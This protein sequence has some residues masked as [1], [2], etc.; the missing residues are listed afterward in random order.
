MPEERLIDPGWLIKARQ[1]RKTLVAQLA[2][3]FVL[4]TVLA[5]WIL[6]TFRDRIEDIRKAVPVA[7]GGKA[8]AEAEKLPALASL[9]ISCVGVFKVFWVGIAVGCGAGGLLALTGKIDTL[10]PLLNWIVLAVGL[11]AVALSFYVLY[12]PTLTLLQRVS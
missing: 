1:R 12:L 9:L 3:V 4:L 2:V 10:V 6:P 5:W 7:R 8:K 11:G